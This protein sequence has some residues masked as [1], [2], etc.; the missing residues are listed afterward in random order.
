MP[1][2]FIGLGSNLGNRSEFLMR[3]LEEIQRL[4][5]IVFKKSSSVYDTDPVGIKAQPKFL[6]MVVEVDS[7][8]PPGELLQKL[9]Q[10]ERSIGRKKSERWGPRE[11][12]LDLLYYGDE[13]MN[14]EELKLPH[15]EIAN[16]RF[17]LVPMKEI[18]ADFV[19]PLHKRTIAELLS[20]CTDTSAVRKTTRE[21]SP[22]RGARRA[23]SL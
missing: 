14:D 2:V 8:M 3:A 1:R 13:I 18:A 23:A 19:D 5:G 11:I 7:V 22:E 10:I 9:K 16:R 12:D 20:S 4:G 21:S 15:P 6:N 17:V